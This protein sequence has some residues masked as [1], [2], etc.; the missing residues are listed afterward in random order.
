[1]EGRE[2]PQMA[3]PAQLAQLQTLNLKYENSFKQSEL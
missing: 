2:N 3:T 1:M